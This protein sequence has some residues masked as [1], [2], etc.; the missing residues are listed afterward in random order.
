V[1]IKN[2]AFIHKANILLVGMCVV[3]HN[4]KTSL[5]LLLLCNVETVQ[6][7]NLDPSSD[8]VLDESVLATRR[9]VNLSNGTKLGV[10]TEDEIV[11]GGG[12]LLLARLAVLA[13]VDL[14]L[15]C[16]P[17]GLSVEE[18][19]EEVVG[20]LTGALGEDTV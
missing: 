20:E 14:V 3:Y 2:F 19:N 9:G 18:V 6:L 16:L 4:L 13:S 1:N 11:T 7:H 5:E 17:L 12:P 10:R 8:K 15:T